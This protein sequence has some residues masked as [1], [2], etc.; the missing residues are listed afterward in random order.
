M[1]QGTSVQHCDFCGVSSFLKPQV[2]CDLAMWDTAEYTTSFTGCLACA[3]WG[4]GALLLGCVIISGHLRW[5]LHT[6][7]FSPSAFFDCLDT[8][9][10]VSANVLNR[11]C[12]SWRMMI[13]KNHNNIYM[14]NHYRICYVKINKVMETT[15]VKLYVPH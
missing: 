13:F 12:N 10:F 14:V 6:C 7:Y 5:C 2:D 4:G 15:G 9:A 1:C 11:G 3:F 8:S